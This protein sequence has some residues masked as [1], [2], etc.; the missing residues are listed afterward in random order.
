MKTYESGVQASNEG[1]FQMHPGSVL[2]L[3][4]HVQL[5]LVTQIFQT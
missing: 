5:A 3:L 1:M 2:Q 4:A